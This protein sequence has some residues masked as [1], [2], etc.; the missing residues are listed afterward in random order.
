MTEKNILPGHKDDGLQWVLFRLGK[1]EYAVMAT[2]VQEI[3]RSASITLIPNMPE[4][5]KGICNLRGKIIP[6]L[7]LKER[8]AIEG[9][10]DQQ[11]ARIIVAHVETQMVG[12]TV[13]SVVGVIRMPPEVVEPVPENLPKI[14]VE[15]I[16]GVAKL[17]GH[18]VL[19]LNM[20]KILKNVEKMILETSQWGKK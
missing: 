13:D 15:Y 5:V 16:T 9:E 7:D 17:S 12:F 11:Q 8:F 6:L 14:D 18:L 2:Q 10:T 4:F 20:D 1:E 3:V 19:L